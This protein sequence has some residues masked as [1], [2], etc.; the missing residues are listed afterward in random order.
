VRQAQQPK[1]DGVERT[2]EERESFELS[3]LDKVTEFWQFRNEVC[4]W[5]Q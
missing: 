3:D 2:V 4:T 1:D 5:N